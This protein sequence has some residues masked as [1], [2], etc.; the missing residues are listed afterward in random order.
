MP[1]KTVPDT[2]V[3]IGAL[4]FVPV[5]SADNLRELRAELGQSMS[6][7]GRTLRRALDPSPRAIPFTRQYIDR[8]EKGKDRITPEIQA[9]FFAIAGVM[10][11]VPSGVGGTIP[12]TV[13]ALPGQI[14]PGAY[15]PPEYVTVRCALPG[16]PVQFVKPRW[17]NRAY[18]H[19]DCKKRMKSLRRKGG[20]VTH[21]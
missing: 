8:L 21:V 17:S 7:F 12:T 5:V 14:T 2:S 15:L 9:A 6:E 10:D 18:H 3:K 11:S 4:T 13:M 16:C 20:G 19:P 1:R